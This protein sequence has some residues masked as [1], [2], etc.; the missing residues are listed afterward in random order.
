MRARLIPLLL[1]ATGVLACRSRDRAHQPLAIHDVAPEQL[2]RDL[3]TPQAIR[4]LTE[5]SLAAYERASVA[6][7]ATGRD[8]DAAA[9]ALHRILAE[10]G[11][12]IAEAKALSNVPDLLER[13]RPVLEE[14]TERT[15]ALTDRFAA[16]TSRCASNPRVAELLG[17]F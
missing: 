17:Y 6:L 11:Q 4:A 8:C 13:A 3:A 5:R 12:A 14:Q 7:E 16:A 15:R 10:D 9:D 2:R 1:A